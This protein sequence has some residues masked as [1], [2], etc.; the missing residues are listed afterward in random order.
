MLFW[1]LLGLNRE[2]LRRMPF[3]E[4]RLYALALTELTL[5]RP[6]AQQ[7]VDTSAGSAPALLGVGA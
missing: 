3:D 2:A 4:Y 6:T 5:K 1:R 7:T